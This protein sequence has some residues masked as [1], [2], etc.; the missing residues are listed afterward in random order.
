M[1]NGRSSVP[2]DNLEASEND[3]EV[4]E[5]PTGASS[6]E[7]ASSSKTQNDGVA[8]KGTDGTVDQGVAEELRNELDETKRNIRRLQSTYDSK[9]DEKEQEL[10]Q[11]ERELR[12]QLREEKMRGMD[13]SEKLAFENQ[14]LQQEL[15]QTQQQLQQRRQLEQQRER[16]NAWANEAIRQTGMSPDKIDWSDPQSTISSTWQALLEA[17]SKGGQQ[18]QQMVEDQQGQSSQQSQNEGEVRPPD[19]ETGT[20]QASSATPTTWPET[21]QRLNSEKRLGR[22]DWTVDGVK[23]AVRRGRLPKSIIERIIRSRAQTLADQAS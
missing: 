12:Q 13:E 2:G 23:E 4:V 20:G 7:S 10:R 19:V 11:R 8:Q 6:S 14:Y 1:P 9:L 22:D 3:A 17:A 21:V 18:A 15:E 16:A 5:E